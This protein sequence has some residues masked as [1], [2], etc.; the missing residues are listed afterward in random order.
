MATEITAK[1]DLIAGTGSA[2][3]DNLPVGTNGQTLVADST[4]S[5]GLKWAAPAGGGKVLQVVQGTTTT[6]VSNSTTTLADTTL[7]ATIT[8]SATTSKIL[9]IISQN[10]CYKSAGNTQ[11]GITLDLLRGASAIYHFGDAELYTGTALQNNG[12]IS[13]SYLDSPATISATTY[14]TQFRNSTAAAAVGVQIGSATTS[15]IILLEIGA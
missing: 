10:D 11:S 12:C 14:K 9:V 3:F 8:P 6:P 5:T 2:T 13:A 4:A 15:T 1:G 7:S